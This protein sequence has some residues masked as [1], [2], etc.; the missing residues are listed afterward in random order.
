MLYEDGCSGCAGFLRPCLLVYVSTPRVSVELCAYCI[1]C[2]WAIASLVRAPLILAHLGFQSNMCGFS[3]PCN[4]KVGVIIL[5]F[6]TAS[7]S[8]VQGFAANGPI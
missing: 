3:D 8:D 1:V 7:K 2:A 4:D 5:T 6:L